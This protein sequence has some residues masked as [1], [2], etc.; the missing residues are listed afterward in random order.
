MTID[1]YDAWY[2]AVELCNYEEVLVYHLPL[3]DYK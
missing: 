3:E 2:E 1:D